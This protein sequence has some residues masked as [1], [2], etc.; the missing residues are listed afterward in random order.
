YSFLSETK[1]ELFYSPS[2]FHTEPFGPGWAWD[3]YNY[4]FSPERSPF[5]IYGNVVRVIA[6]HGLL[7][8]TPDYFAS[9]FTAGAP[10]SRTRIVRQPHRNV[11]V[12]HPMEP[13]AVVRE[14]RIPFR[15]DTATFSA[16]L[17]DTL[18]RFVRLVNTPLP[19]DAR[20]RFSVH[21]DSL[22]KVM[23]QESDNFIAEQLLLMCADALSD[24]LR[25]EIVIDFM[26]TYHLNDLP[27]EPV[28]VDCSG[29]S[30]YNLV[31]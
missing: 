2:N 11:F 12:I 20:T 14:I 15:A 19:H 25:P 30:R 4:G 10:A 31:T 16:V 1:R 3:D 23:M 28:W 13:P 5:P 17:S 26:K 18:K 27:D 7:R 21:V 29:L 9:A 6:D 24:S 22:Y 8:V